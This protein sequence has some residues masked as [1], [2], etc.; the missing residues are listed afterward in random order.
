MTQQIDFNDVIPRAQAGDLKAHNELM[1][2]F[3]AWSV[4]QAHEVVR[5]SEMAKNI[6]VEFWTWLRNGGI[7][8]CRNMDSFYSWMAT[9]IRNLAVNVVRKKRPRIFYG[10]NTAPGKGGDG[11]TYHNNRD[12]KGRPIECGVV[13]TFTNECDLRHDL[14]VF[15][16]RLSPSARRVLNLMLD[17]ATPQAIA[18]ECGFS[19]KRAQNLIGSIRKQ[20]KDEVL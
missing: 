9:V 10:L 2:A 1:A 4:T 16:K 17:G 5:D 13:P 14:A 12:R 6:A 20:I 19:R 8:E 3:Y 15:A 11:Y 18:D 7:Q